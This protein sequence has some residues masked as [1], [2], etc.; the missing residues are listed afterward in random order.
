MLGGLYDRTIT[1][2]FLAIK[3]IKW[4]AI[5]MDLQEIL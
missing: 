2:G 4:V 5:L 1:Y 3:K